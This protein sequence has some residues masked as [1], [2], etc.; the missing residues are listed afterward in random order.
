MDPITNS[1]SASPSH[2]SILQSSQSSNTQTPLS[3]PP[4]PPPGTSHLPPL[5]SSPPLPPPPPLNSRSPHTNLASP[6]SASSPPSSAADLNS[7]STHDLSNANSERDCEENPERLVIKT[8]PLSPSTSD[9]SQTQQALDTL[10]RLFPGR[11]IPV[12]EAVLLHSGGDVLKAIQT[13]L[14]SH[15][16]EQNGNS[17]SGLNSS[18]S[19]LQSESLTTS[20]P[21]R[22]PQN[23]ISASNGNNF[24]SRTPPSQLPPPPS[25][26]SVQRSPDPPRPYDFFQDPN[27]MLRAPPFN[28]LAPSSLGRFPYSPHHAFLGLPY[29]PFLPPRP[30]YYPP[31]NLSAHQS[32]PPPLSP[33]TGNSSYQIMSHSSSPTPN[34]TSLSPSSAQ[35]PDSD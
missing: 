30:E 35:D 28:P 5:S 22:T 15:S 6:P 11:R 25:A 18:P 19:S 1:S 21:S 12:L 23:R 17:N 14:Y 20:T 10:I 3:S 24:R 8:D 34:D 7:S 16:L 4:T 29:S 13:L 27:N 26:T 2:A 32:V 9:G 31:L 33:S